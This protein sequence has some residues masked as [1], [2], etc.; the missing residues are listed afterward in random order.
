[1]KNL[2][3]RGVSRKTVFIMSPRIQKFFH[4]LKLFHINTFEN[5]R[6]LSI[7]IEDSF[8]LYCR[9]AETIESRHTWIGYCRVEKGHSIKVYNDAEIGMQAFVPH[10]P[11]T[12]PSI[13]GPIHF[14]KYS[15]DNASGKI[16]E[17][18]SKLDAGNG[19]QSNRCILGKTH[20]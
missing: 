19:I 2:Q 8:V 3:I 9:S 6:K 7:W 11:P 17:F 10:K 14:S 16:D 12:K 4:D 15:S 18:I 5:Y 1:M 13:S 20:C